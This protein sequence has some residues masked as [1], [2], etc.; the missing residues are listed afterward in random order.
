MINKII[1]GE[2][3]QPRPPLYSKCQCM[4]TFMIHPAVPD[5]P[6]VTVQTGFITAFFAVTTVVLYL[7]LVSP[8]PDPSVSH[9]RSSDQYTLNTD[10]QLVESSSSSRRQSSGYDL[11]F[12]LPL[13]KLYTNSLMSTLN[14]RKMWMADFCRSDSMDISFG[15]HSAARGPRWR[16][17]SGSRSGN[18]GT[19]GADVNVDGS[20]G[21]GRTRVRA[22][23]LNLPN[24]RRGGR[25][26]RPLRSCV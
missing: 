4:S 14:S 26:G 16:S 10:H 18:R 11:L 6:P 13:A 22:F 19:G 3:H 1:R 20:D 23:F 8:P 17:R 2:S 7:T 15:T 21:R 12:H 5:R 9:T 24:V 25:G